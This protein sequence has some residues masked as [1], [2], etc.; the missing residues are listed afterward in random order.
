MPTAAPPP[1]LLP[2]PKW[3][4]R[5]PKEGTLSRACQKA[6][7]FSTDARQYSPHR[8]SLRRPRLLRAWRPPAALRPLL[9]SAGR[10]SRRQERPRPR[11]PAPLASSFAFGA[12][13]FEEASSASATRRAG[14][15]RRVR[16]TR[17]AE[18]RH[19]TRYLQ[20]HHPRGHT[21]VWGGVHAPESHHDRNSIY[22]VCVT[23]IIAS[24]E[25]Q[26]PKRADKNRECVSGRR[27]SLVV[28]TRQQVSELAMYCQKSGMPRP[29][30]HRVF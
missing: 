25:H 8:T 26:T 30:N 1:P 23:A 7:F 5:G 10:A 12:L 28:S 27:S 2:P 17:C 4:S 24:S 14:D 19:K 6:C 20:R 11:G 9:P 15:V 22:H 13:A 21:E 29:T 3:C 18:F 16:H